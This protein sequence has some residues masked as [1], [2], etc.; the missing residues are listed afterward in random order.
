MSMENKNAQLLDWLESQIFDGAPFGDV[1]EKA[2]DLSELDAYR[3]RDALMKRR[4]AKGDP[5]IGY[6]VA[7][8]ARVIQV[9]EH[10]EGATVGC[11]MRSGWIP[12]GEAF[13]VADYSR[14]IVESEVAVILKHDLAGPGVTPLQAL[15]A[16]EGYCPA[17]EV[18]AQRPM[19]KRSHAMRILGTKFSGGG[20]VVG[21]P[22][23]APHGIDLR[24]EGMVISING[25]VK[26]S[27]TGVEVMGDPVNSVAFMA[28]KL[29]EI[30]VPIKAGMVLMTGSF[31][32]NLPVKAGDDVCVEFTRLGRVRTSFK[33]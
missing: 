13:S 25:E 24:L 7:G 3:L 33:A 14:V 15:Q 32:G 27:A 22:M 9:T 26:G 6:K 19:P 1:T 29:G 17:I 11:L 5:H 30:G 8:A 18:I 10:A 16:I 21:G 12:E 20:I 4:V 2:P 31:I 28:N 23:S